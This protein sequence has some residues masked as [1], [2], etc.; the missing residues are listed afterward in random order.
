VPTGVTEI[1]VPRVRVDFKIS[2]IK[3]QK[4]FV[5][6]PVEIRSLSPEKFWL[7]PASVS[8][9]VSGVPERMAGLKMDEVIPFVR[10]GADAQ[11]AVEVQVATDAPREIAVVQIDPPKV[12]IVRSGSEAEKKSASRKV[13]PLK[14][15]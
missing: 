2:V 13:I 12:R 6:V 7:S 5:N 11:D 1:S 8:I 10:I 4:K 14:K 15:P 3:S 9:E